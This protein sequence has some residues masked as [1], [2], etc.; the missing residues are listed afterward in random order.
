MPDV[1]VTD[2]VKEQPKALPVTRSMSKTDIHLFSLSN[3]YNI[4]A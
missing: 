3:I 4:R 1:G 2:V